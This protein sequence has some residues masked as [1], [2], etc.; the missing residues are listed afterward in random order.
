MVTGAGHQGV[1]VKRVADA[2][3]RPV[4][5]LSRDEYYREV[6]ALR[7][8]VVELEA[9]NRRMSDALRPAQV[10]PTEWRLTPSEQ[11]V[12]MALHRARRGLTKNGIHAAL[13]FDTTVEVEL[14]IVDVFI[15][16]VRAKLKARGFDR[17]IDTIW[18]NG[19]ALTESFRAVIDAAIAEP[20]PPL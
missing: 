6:A 4:I 8:R 9:D 19:Y 11:T 13:Y 15:C 17:A 14:K 5:P 18:G 2:D 1:I 10:L 3:V 7:R 20:R 12:I 16:K